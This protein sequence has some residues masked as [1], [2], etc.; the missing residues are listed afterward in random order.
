MIETT[1]TENAACFSY[2]YERRLNMDKKELKEQY[3]QIKPDMGIFAYKCLPSG[4][5]YLGIGQNIR[6][7]INS[8]SF[9]LN[10]GKYPANKNLENDWKYYGE[11]GFEI[12]VL[13]LLEYDNEGVKTDYKDDLR[14][15]RELWSE[16]FDDVEYIKK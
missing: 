16:K 12:S 13:E 14:A 5:V 9:Q 15:L 7:D 8:L 6:A 1:V 2:P 10:L 3:K 4:K 11:K